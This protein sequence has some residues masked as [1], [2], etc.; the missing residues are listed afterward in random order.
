MRK[1][2]KLGVGWRCSPVVSAREKIFYYI[3]VAV[4][5]AVKKHVLKL[6]IGRNLQ[7]VSAYLLLLMP[8]NREWEHHHASIALLTGDSGRTR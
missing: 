4:D 5:R 1:R 8:L 6:L 7:A 2:A 3:P